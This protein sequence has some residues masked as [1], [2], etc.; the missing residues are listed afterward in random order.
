MLQFDRSNILKGGGGG[1]GSHGADGKGGGM[2]KGN[3]GIAPGA[4]EVLS[5]FGWVELLAPDSTKHHMMRI[6]GIPAFHSEAE[7]IRAADLLPVLQQCWSVERQELPVHLEQQEEARLGRD[8]KRETDREET[9]ASYLERLHRKESMV[10]GAQTS[11]ASISLVLVF[12]PLTGGGTGA[13]AGAAGAGACAGAGAGVW[14]GWD[15]RRT[16]IRQVGHVC[17]LGTMSEGNYNERN[18]QFRICIKMSTP[19]RLIFSIN[20]ASEP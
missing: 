11:A 15:A 14:F 8:P 16:S 1:I 12:L 17:C 18:K 6:M 9:E 7:Q 2:E 10:Y 19:K 5:A 3:P 20:S 13:L 4:A